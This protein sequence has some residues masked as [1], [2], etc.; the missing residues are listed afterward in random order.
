MTTYK[1]SRASYP[2]GILAIYENRKTIDRYTVVF[3]PDVVDGVAW[4]TTLHM[5]E[6]IGNGQGYC[7]HGQYSFRPTRAQGD[8][9]IDFDALPADCRTAVEWDLQQT[10]GGAT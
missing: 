10:A 9:V 4:F 3:T 1:K 7:Q 8:R 5:S 2:D 6:K